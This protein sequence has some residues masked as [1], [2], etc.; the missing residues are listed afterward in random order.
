MDL[1]LVGMNITYQKQLSK[2]A[3]TTHLFLYRKKMFLHLLSHF[4]RQKFGDQ[5]I[6]DSK[7]VNIENYSTRVVYIL[8]TSV[9]LFF[10]FYSYK[11]L[12]F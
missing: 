5:K 6:I 12:G 7:N 3:L 2:I 11:Y 10:N 9:V 8:T 4:I 1:F